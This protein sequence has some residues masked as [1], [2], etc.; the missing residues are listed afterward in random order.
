MKK[1]KNGISGTGLYIADMVYAGQMF[2]FFTA[3]VTAKE[4][5]TKSK[6]QGKH[7]NE[8]LP[9]GTN[10]GRGIPNNVVLHHALPRCALRLVHR[11]DVRRRRE[12]PT[13]ILN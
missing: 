11:V 7:R 13:I 12:L 6:Y 3:T 10:C 4:I 9:L 8:S 1:T 5:F 2:P